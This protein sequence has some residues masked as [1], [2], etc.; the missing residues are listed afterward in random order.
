MAGRSFR[1]TALPISGVDEEGELAILAPLLPP[2]ASAR[3]HL[4]TLNMLLAHPDTA[5]GLRRNAKEADIHGSTQL[6]DVI[7]SEALESQLLPPTLNWPLDPDDLLSA[8]LSALGY[9]L[10][11]RFEQSLEP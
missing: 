10:R 9:L 7:S 6:I 2:D 11:S 5:A 3:H 8:R 1:T 4:R